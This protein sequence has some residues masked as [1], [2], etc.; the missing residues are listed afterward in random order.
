M[1]LILLKEGIQMRYRG[2]VAVAT[3]SER[4]FHRYPAVPTFQVS[5]DLWWVAALDSTQRRACMRLES[6]GGI[7]LETLVRAENELELYSS[8]GGISS[9]INRISDIR[10]SVVSLPL[11]TSL[12]K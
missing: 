5:G 6:F 8:S 2:S 1:N 11:S 12:M 4:G 9:S 3:D 10:I 7:V